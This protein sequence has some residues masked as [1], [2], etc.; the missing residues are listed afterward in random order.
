MNYSVMVTVL[1]VTSLLVTSILLS[2]VVGSDE[3]SM[4][5]PRKTKMSAGVRNGLGCTFIGLGIWFE[6][7]N[8]IFS[9]S[10]L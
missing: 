3:G 7:L 6:R 1:P 9:S 2:A 5:G 4:H 8:L 10:T